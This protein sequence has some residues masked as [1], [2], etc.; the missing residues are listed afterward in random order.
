MSDRGSG[1]IM[2]N[3]LRKRIVFGLIAGLTVPAGFFAYSLD[4]YVG[5]TLIVVVAGMFVLG[6]I[7]TAAR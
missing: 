5:V 1:Q 3:K 7:D 4:G 6:N 2:R